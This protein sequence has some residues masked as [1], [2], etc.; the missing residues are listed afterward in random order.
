MPLTE[1]TKI[2]KMKEVISMKIIDE[3]GVELT[4]APDLTLGRLIDDAETVHHEAVEAVK[5]VCH[6]VTTKTYPNGSAEVEEVVDVA[7]VAAKP[8]WD[9]TVPVQR[10]VRYTEAELAEQEAQ[11]EHETKMAQMPET[12]EQLQAENARLKEQLEAQESSMTN[13]QLAL[14]SLYEAAETEDGGEA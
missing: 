2:A 14:C 6:Y 3:N 13:L 8:A 10:Y 9:E 11:R 7:P 12:V 1:N 4:E 5:K